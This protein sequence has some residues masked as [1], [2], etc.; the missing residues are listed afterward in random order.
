[1]HTYYIHTYLHTSQL[2]MQ[3]Y[4]Y[5]R[6][7]KFECIY[8]WICYSEIYSVTVHI[9]HIEYVTVNIFHCNILGYVTVK[10]ILNRVEE[11]KHF[12]R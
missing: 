12:K 1:M 5:K 2:Y 6:Y 7:T 11:K 8:T 4:T 3:I 9:F 10:Y